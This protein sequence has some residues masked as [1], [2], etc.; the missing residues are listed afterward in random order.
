MIDTVRCTCMIS[1][2]L[3]AAL[4]GCAPVGPGGGSDVPCLRPDAW[5]DAARFLARPETEGSEVLLLTHQTYAQQEEDREDGVLGNGSHGPVY[6]FDPETEV[7]D[8]VDDETWDNSNGAVTDCIS[9]SSRPS[10]I[11][12]TSGLTFEGEPI[13][14]RGRMALSVHP[15]P[16]S[17]A[18]AVLSTDGYRTGIPFLS[19]GGAT[20]AGG[21]SISVRSVRIDSSG[22]RSC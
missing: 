16:H 13:Q 2:M 8:L 1:L 6:R 3:M 11:R 9:S 19:L 7:F 5:P 14:V 18:A 22:S 20:P 21:L 10:S 4:G 12:R 15:A 17:P